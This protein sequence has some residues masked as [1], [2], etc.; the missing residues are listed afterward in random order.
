MAPDGECPIRRKSAIDRRVIGRANR[1]IST[2]CA[3]AVNVK[4]ECGKRSAISNT[5][6]SD[7]AR[8]TVVPAYLTTSGDCPVE[9][10]PATFTAPFESA[11]PVSDAIDAAAL[12]TVPPLVMLRLP[13]PPFPT[14]I[15]SLTVNVPKLLVPTE[16]VPESAVFRPRVRVLELALGACTKICAVPPLL[17]SA[18]V[19][20]SGHPRDQFPQVNQLPVASVQIVGAPKAAEMGSA[21]P[22]M[23]SR[24]AFL[25]N[26][27][28]ICEANFFFIV[29]VMKLV[30][31][32][33]MLT[34]V[35]R[36]SQ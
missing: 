14:K 7:S 11:L 29:W 27:R 1:A 31:F 4:T 17:I 28:A 5:Q 22:A 18:S 20:E 24:I 26:F 13:V 15:V 33:G 19:T 3:G 12:L 23:M 6:E 30:A 36:E 32:E 16:T 21:K 8:A 2:Q 34:L 9:P 25:V 35:R 10:V